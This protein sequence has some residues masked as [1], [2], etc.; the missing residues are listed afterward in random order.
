MKY[1]KLIILITTII[2]SFPAFAQLEVKE[3]SF[4][5]VKGFVNINTDKMYDDNDKPYAVL[6]IRTENINNRQRRELSF[7]GDAATFIETEYKDEYYFIYEGKNIRVK[8]YCDDELNRQQE[9]IRNGDIVNYYYYY[10]EN[11]ESG[12]VDRNDIFK[13]FDKYDNWLTMIEDDGTTYIR[14][15]EYTE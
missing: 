11:R 15:F 1:I 2:I 6:K 8:T 12:R 5:E 7:S 4:K 13:D 14:E 10:G 3:G 9:W